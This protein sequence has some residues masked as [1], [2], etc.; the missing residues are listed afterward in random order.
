MG[1]QSPSA[2]K[3]RSLLAEASKTLMNSA[4]F[5]KCLL[6]YMKH[7]SMTKI[8]LFKEYEVGVYNYF[9]LW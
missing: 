7:E 5:I 1:I 8:T 2:L 3:K 6:L 4:L 9:F